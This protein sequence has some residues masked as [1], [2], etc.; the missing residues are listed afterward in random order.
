MAIKS[1]DQITIVDVTDAY[2]VM[3][4]SEAYTFVGGPGGVAAGA[5][6]STEAVA[7]CGTNQCPVVNVTAMPIDNITKFAW[8]DDDYETVEVFVEYTEEE[9]AEIARREAAST[10]T[11]IADLDDAICALYEEN[12]ALKNTS[13]DLDDAVCYLYEQILEVNNDK[14]S[15]T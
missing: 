6:C 5:S 12:L 10:D 7:F 13:A 3:L 14:Q 11:I 9:M 2:S 15:N 1:A 8:N 4:T